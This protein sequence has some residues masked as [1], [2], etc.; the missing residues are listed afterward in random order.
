[1]G[2]G[3]VCNPQYLLHYQS[4]GTIPMEYIFQK[5]IFYN[6]GIKYSTVLRDNTR[7]HIPL[8]GNYLGMISGVRGL[9]VFSPQN[10]KLVSP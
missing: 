1:M 5:E 9:M 8:S 2:T 7:G 3:C 6:F 10:P 4:A